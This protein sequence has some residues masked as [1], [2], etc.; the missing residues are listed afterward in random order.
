MF[1]LDSSV[2]VAALTAEDHTPRA[3]QWAAQASKGIVFISDWVSAEVSA[4]LTAKLRNRDLTE[5]LWR[6]AL[7]SYRALGNTSFARL[8]IRRAS[9]EQ[10][11]RLVELSRRPLS[12][13][14]ALHLALA[15]HHEVV[16]ATL[17]RRQA[18]AAAALGIAAE[19]I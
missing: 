15:K 13:G 6:E 12:A 3:Q 8:P 1:Y 17:D 14:D 5:S 4:A 9:F 10:A 16:L 18:D 7:E 11:A 2:V 19:L